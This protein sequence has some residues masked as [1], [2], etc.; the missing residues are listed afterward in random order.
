MLVDAIRKLLHRAGDDPSTKVT[1]MANS[2]KG[3]FIGGRT[4]AKGE[5]FTTTEREAFEL[6][7]ATNRWGEQLALYVDRPTPPPQLII[8][9]EKESAGP[10]RPR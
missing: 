4:Y 10:L 9:A 5:T 8:Y 1:M 7:K 2:R 3:V 6:V